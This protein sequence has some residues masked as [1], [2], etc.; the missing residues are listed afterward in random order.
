[1]CFGLVEQSQRGVP[2]AV[3]SQ[4]DEGLQPLQ[5]QAEMCSS[6]GGDPIKKRH[7][8]LETAHMYIMESIFPHYCHS[9]GNQLFD[10]STSN[11]I[12]MPLFHLLGS[13]SL[14][15]L[16]SHPYSLVRH[17]LTPSQLHMDLSGTRFKICLGQPDTA[18]LILWG[19]WSEDSHYPFK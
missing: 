13:M 12:M 14:L 7:F 15:D 11:L 1:M 8:S 6:G 10:T 4:R 5:T 2:T 16:S 9:Q 18:F 17:H 3:W 19:L